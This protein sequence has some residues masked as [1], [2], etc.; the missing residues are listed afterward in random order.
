M[1]VK[2]KMAELNTEALSEQR[3][4]D[5]ARARKTRLKI[6]DNRPRVRERWNIRYTDRCIIL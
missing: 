5:S 6:L 2:I 3:E 1:R 4:R